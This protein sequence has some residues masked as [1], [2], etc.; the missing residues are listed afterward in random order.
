M[1]LR[2]FLFAI[3]LAL[4]SLPLAA[5]MLSTGVGS[6]GSSSSPPPYVAS[7]VHLDGATYIDIAAVTATDSGLFAYSGWLKS[8]LIGSDVNWVFAFD[9]FNNQNPF[10]TILGSLD[11]AAGTMAFYYQGVA[12]DVEFTTNSGAWPADTNW[13]HIFV[14][15]NTN[16]ATPTL[17]FY[18]DG[19]LVTTFLSA[20]GGPFISQF[21]GI[22]FSMPDNPSSG[23]GPPFL[24]GDIADWWIA[25]GSSETDVTVFRDPITGKPK[26]PNTFPSAAIL[27]SGDATMFATNQGSG[28]ATITTGILTNALTHP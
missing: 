12:G 3:L 10:M 5:Q 15:A 26:N 2:A 7:A 14:F 18:L 28:G 21:S 27:F 24:I 4:A 6:N 13:H 20:G 8:T 1:K 25:P 16:L 9:P 11:V 22:E 17:S 19:A 23:H